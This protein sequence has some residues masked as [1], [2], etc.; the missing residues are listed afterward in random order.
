MYMYGVRADITIKTGL[1]KV[2]EK[3]IQFGTVILEKRR[4]AQK[5]QHINTLGFHLQKMFAPLTII[6]LVAP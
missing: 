1:K 5:K 6:S 2:P 3:G 4:T